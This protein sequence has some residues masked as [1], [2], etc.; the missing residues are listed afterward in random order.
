HKYRMDLIGG[1]TVSGTELSISITIIGYVDK[2]K[3]RYRHHA[4]S[5][6][7]VF[8][9]G[10]LGDSQAGFH[11]LTN[12]GDYIDEAYYVSRH[13]MPSPRINFAKAL[14]NLSR[15]ALND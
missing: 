8:V 5:G 15:V 14:V 10:T 11:M 12:N 7:V 13:Q 6:D 4:S 2:G 1:D 3:A 9:T